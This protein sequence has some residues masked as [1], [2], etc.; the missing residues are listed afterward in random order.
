[1]S[2]GQ[3]NY[4]DIMGAGGRYRINEIGCFLTS[5][6]NLLERFGIGVSPADL[7]RAFIQR[8]VYIDIDD[9]IK[10]DL[11]WQSITAYNGRIGTTVKSGQVDNRNSIVRIAAGGRW[12]THFCLVERIENGVVYVVDSWDGV[13]KPASVYGPITGF[14]VYDIINP[15]QV[16]VPDMIT[17]A[18]ID[19]LRIA[20]SEIGGWDLAE[21]H[22]GKYDDLFLRVY[23]GQPAQSLVRAQWN[24]HQD[25]RNARVA[26]FAAAK[27]LANR[28]S[29]ET[30]KALQ[31][32]LKLCQIA[33]QA[34]K[35]TAK[36]LQAEKDA[37]AAAG[38]S[39]LRKL[40]QLLKR[41]LPL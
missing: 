7:N 5:F 34:A 15:Q 38:D 22:A 17:E 36:D 37:D 19:V 18:D 13:V 39:F 12:G 29:Q 31:N 8:G 35:D 9:G 30:L 23:K 28:P 2:Y 41:Y 26:A 4:A 3:K 25:W 20:H 40:G 27:E 1:M 33:E 11:G 21:V 24:Q 6:S 16:G 10:D 14:A 32:S